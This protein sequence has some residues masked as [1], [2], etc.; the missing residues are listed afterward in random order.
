VANDESL[1]LKS[2]HPLYPGWHTDLTVSYYQNVTLKHHKDQYLLKLPLT[3]LFDKTPT[4]YHTITLQMPFGSH[5]YHY[6][7][8]SSLV[9]RT[10]VESM[11]KG[12][13]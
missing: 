3:H 7:I 11:A 1:I 10:V 4:L 12:Y 13:R 9:N 2:R 6:H 5:N 8:D